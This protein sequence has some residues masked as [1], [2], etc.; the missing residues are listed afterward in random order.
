MVVAGRQKWTVMPASMA[1]GDGG[2]GQRM[3]ESQKQ[4]CS[5]HFQ[6]WKTGGLVNYM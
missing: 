4:A 2:G 1:G 6:G 5:A 3:S